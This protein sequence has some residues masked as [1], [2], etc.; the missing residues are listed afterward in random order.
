MRLFLLKFSF[1]CFLPIFTTLRNEIG[2]VSL[3]GQDDHV[4][5][6]LTEDGQPIPWKSATVIRLLKQNVK[7]TVQRLTRQNFESDER[8]DVVLTI[9][10]ERNSEERTDVE[11]T[12]I[13]NLNMWKWL[14]AEH[15][16]KLSNL[17][18]TTGD[19]ALLLEKA[20][21]Q[22]LLTD[23]ALREMAMRSFRETCRELLRA[24]LG[25]E[26]YE[27]VANLYKSGQRGKEITERLNEFYVQL[28]DMNKKYADMIA[29]TC[30]SV[31]DIYQ[32]PSGRYRRSVAE[33]TLFIKEIHWLTKEQE[34]E[35]E[36]MLAEG[37]KNE[38]LLAKIL[39]YYEKLDS[40]SQEKVS[41]ELKQLCQ[42]QVKKLFG[43]DAREIVRSEH[44]KL[45]SAESLMS[46][47]TEL[48]GNLTNEN[49][50]TEADQVRIF[51][52]KIYAS[53]SFDLSEL[54]SW[55]SPDQ[56][57]EL[58]HLIRDHEV[59]DD[60]VYARIF[61]FYEAAEDKK[62]MDAQRIIESGCRRFVGRMFGTEIAAKLEEHR[63]DGNF[64]AQMLS[65]ELAT[66]AA[67]IK[68]PKNRVKA[69]KSIPICNRIYFGYKGDC[70][71]NGHSS[72]CGPFT[73]EC[74]DCADNTFGVQCEKCL[75][76]FD[77]S[78]LMGGIGCV[79]TGESGEFTG[80]MCNKHST[81]CNENGEC[82][83][84]L[85]NTTG[86]HCEKCAEGFYGDATHGTEE[87][88]IPCPCPN[89]GD[90]FI[91]GDALVECRTCTNGTYG[92]TC[93]LQMEPETTTRITETVT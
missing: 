77:G 63:L 74:L 54:T 20:Y 23:G 46:T 4:A 81:E 86:N 34:T 80:C 67:E 27:L 3:V 29:P 12:Q 58:G 87:D 31:Y 52:Q 48:V 66:Y 33:D 30:M 53:E 75:D 88:C 10:V 16:Y 82:F 19:L 42:N 65:A 35:I 18:K 21:V 90:C 26:N 9:P 1:L 11:W 62:K 51:C 25:D 2:R 45:T 84:C 69:E 85:H 76:G 89:G 71:C 6:F 92:S 93:E 59:S 64:T 13:G 72:T 43:S 41:D 28:S 7:P 32:L 40:S 49:K 8:E 14:T 70:F 91:N 39:E 56:K 83:S 73:H 55:L 38:S 79:A 44:K 36:T 15:A 68:D 57:V 78:A 60:A 22:L 5:K 47:F 61:E 37:A 17:Y 50:R 24:I